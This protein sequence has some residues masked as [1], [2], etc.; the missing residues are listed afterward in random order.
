MVGVAAPRGR[1]RL[2]TVA[3]CALACALAGS[4]VTAASGRLGAAS[5][6]AIL[7]AFP[8]TR[9]RLSSLGRVFGEPGLGPR[10]RLALG[11]AEGVLFGA[12]LAA[13]LTSR[14]R[15]FEKD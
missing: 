2:A 1:S 8:A 7:D 14:R 6:G 10:T 15:R 11:L 9:V 12:G 13:G 3:A 5:L 4:L